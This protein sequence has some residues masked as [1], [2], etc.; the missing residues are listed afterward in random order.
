MT[1]VNII[2]TEINK[3]NYSQTLNKVEGFINDKNQHYIVTPNPEIILKASKNINYRAILNNADLSLPDGFGLI[4]GSWFLGDPLYHRVTGVDLS[5]KITQLANEKG[6]KIF[7][8]GGQNNAA[9][10]AKTKLELK[11]KNIKI[12]GAEEGFKDVQNISNLENQK[13]IKNIKQSQAQIL[14]VA[15]GAPFQ[16]K[17][18]Y[19][20]LKK[21]PNIKLAIGVG[22]TLDFLS[23]KTIRA[24]RLMR[25]IGLEWLWRWFLQ[26]YRAQRIFNATIVFGFDLIK[27]KIYLLKPFR[28]NVV[29]VIINYENN[30]VLVLN[31]RKNLNHWQFP[32]CGIEKNETPEQAVLREM[33]EETQL[34]KLKIIGRID[35]LKRYYWPL[36]WPHNTP[37]KT[38]QY[39]KKWCG[40]EQTIFYL[41]QTENE[42]PNPEEE[43][44]NYKWLDKDELLKTIH[45]I[46]HSLVKT[47]L[48]EINQYINK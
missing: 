17:W 7:L 19:K 37:Q 8:L 28:K 11:Y 4:F 47:V 15:Y 43:H 13:I 16:E 12:V 48:K 21:F 20:N 42:T 41:Q 14:F 18:I 44:Q 40:Q 38:I 1:K 22:G 46:R 30:K 39:N 34:T 5:Y 24:P 9:A 35:K 31:R 32:Q 33:N 26:P 45:P 3:I 2:G 29:G 25:K 10:I 36:Y 27:W 6:Y 23:G